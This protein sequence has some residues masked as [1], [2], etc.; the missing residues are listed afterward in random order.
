[1]CLFVQNPPKNSIYNPIKQINL[2][3]FAPL[4]VIYEV[5]AVAGPREE[6]TSAGQTQMDD[7]DAG[8]LRPLT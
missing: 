3:D 6:F 4:S 7:G 8:T 5:L 1:M 2:P